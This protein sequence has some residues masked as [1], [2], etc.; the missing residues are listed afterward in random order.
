MSSGYPAWDKPATKG[1]V[2]SLGV[3]MM[4]IANSLG[5]VHVRILSGEENA[6]ESS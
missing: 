2:I 3:K 4:T 1:D 5:A 6:R